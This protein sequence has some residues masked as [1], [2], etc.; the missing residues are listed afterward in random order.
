[1][2]APGGAE[3]GKEPVGRLGV[4]G[5]ARGAAARHRVVVADSEARK[6]ATITRPA[7]HP[8]GMGRESL[9]SPQAADGGDGV[10]VAGGVIVVSGTVIV[11]AL[12]ATWPRASLR[13]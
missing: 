3:H 8:E 1:V 9:S 12:P 6:T 11:A 2:R 4:L 13:R 7:P 5:P 10:V